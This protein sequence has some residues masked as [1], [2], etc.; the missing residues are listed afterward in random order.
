MLAFFLCSKTQT[1][2]E[3][4]PKLSGTDC[5]NCYEASNKT[6]GWCETTRECFPGNQYGPYSET[7][8]AWH[9]GMDAYCVEDGSLALPLGW[10][11]GVG[12][13]VGL[14]AIINLIYWL[15]L[16]PRQYASAAPA[17]SAQSVNI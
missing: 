14:F 12:I 17:S 13:F 9:F 4:C 3:L 16:F 10:R 15:V 5:K 8:D 7:C 1:P 2:S 11:I 6:C